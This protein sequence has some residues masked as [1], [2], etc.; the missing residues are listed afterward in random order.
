MKK[1]RGLS[2]GALPRFTGKQ[3]ERQASLYSSPSSKPSALLRKS[4]VPSGPFRGQRELPMPR[5]SFLPLLQQQVIKGPVL[6]CLPP[7]T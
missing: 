2:L 6:L 1:M 3:A 4:R 5:W 7:Q